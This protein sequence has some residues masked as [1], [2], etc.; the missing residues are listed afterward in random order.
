MGLSL[1][2]SKRLNPTQNKVITD[3]KW[4]HIAPTG[5]TYW[6]IH[7]I[8]HPDILDFFI[9]STPSNLPLAIFNISSDHTPVMLVIERETNK[10]P[11]RSSITSD[12]INWTHYKK[13]LSNNKK[14]GIPL[15]TAQ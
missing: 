12:N 1:H 2:L 5:L 7:S 14:L 10:I 13:Y 3:Y 8:W 9:D 4:S 15:K 6:P 11:L